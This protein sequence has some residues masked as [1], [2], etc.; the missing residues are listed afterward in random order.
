MQSYSPLQPQSTEPNCVI[1]Q[2]SIITGMNY[3]NS[4]DATQLVTESTQFSSQFVDSMD[5]FADMD[6][7]SRYFD[8]HHEWFGRCAHPMKADAIGPNSYALTI[9]R[10]GSFGYEVEPKIGLDLLPQAE[11]VYRIETVPVPGY[12]PLGYDVDFRAAMELVELSAE[13]WSE[14]N[15]L[16]LA[17]SESV[18]RVQWKLDL[19]VFIQFPKFIHALP[20][21]LVQST[22]DRVLN[23]VVRQVS[24]RLT[25]KVLEDFHT[26]Y[27]LPVPKRP[28]W[29][30]RKQEE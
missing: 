20:K 4:E 10:F 3:P 8:E 5:M 2:A 26:T 28:K 12:T 22:G 6:M 19:T 14:G 18:T 23:Q 15:G 7:V 21:S 13:H 17:L 25:R 29:R 9:G 11:G 1:Q 16:E 24:G 27:N 30:F